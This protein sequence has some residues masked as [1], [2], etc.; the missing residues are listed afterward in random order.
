MDTNNLV[1]MANA[2]AQYYIEYD[3][4][5]LLEKDNY[6][7]RSIEMVKE[8]ICIEGEPYDYLVAKL[9]VVNNQTGLISYPI[10]YPRYSTGSDN[11]DHW[12]GKCDDLAVRFSIFFDKTGFFSPLWISLEKAGKRY[13][14]KGKRLDWDKYNNVAPKMSYEKYSMLAEYAKNSTSF[15]NAEV[16]H[17]TLPV[18][19]DKFSWVHY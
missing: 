19:L 18:W 3:L 4:R 12:L 1:K 17:R 10:I 9:V 14:P 11:I 8:N 7:L 15:Q 6:T 2:H 16:V 13:E 5:L